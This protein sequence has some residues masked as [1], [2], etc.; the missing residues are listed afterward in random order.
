MGL[1][2]SLIV[3]EGARNSQ[4]CQKGVMGCNKQGGWEARHDGGQPGRLNSG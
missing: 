2:L 3:P 4:Y 1:M